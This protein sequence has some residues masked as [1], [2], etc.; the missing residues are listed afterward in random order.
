[1]TPLIDYAL[2]VTES[3]RIQCTAPALGGTTFSQCPEKATRGQHHGGAP[4]WYHCDRHAEMLRR[5]GRV[6]I[7]LES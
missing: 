6:N 5:T 2:S 4:F 3:A 1:M 7:Q